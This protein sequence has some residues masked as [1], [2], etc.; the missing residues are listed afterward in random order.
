MLGSRLAI[1]DRGLL[2]AQ[3][4]VYLDEI[5]SL[6]EMAA[7]RTPDILIASGFDVVKERRGR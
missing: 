2:Q 7:V 4:V 5:A 3:L 1:A 6:L